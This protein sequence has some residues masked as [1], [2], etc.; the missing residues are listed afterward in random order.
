[1]TPKP[2]NRKTSEKTTA[3]EIRGLGKVF[4]TDL[5]TKV[6]ALQNIDLTVHSGEF[7][8]ILGATGCGKSTFLNL[9]AGLDAPDEGSIRLSDGLQFGENIGYVFQHYTLFPWRTVVKNVGFAQQMRG[10]SKRARKRK[11]S[12][13]LSRVG[14]AGFENAYPH[15]LSGGMRQRAAIAQALAMKPKLLLMDEPFGAVD[16]ATRGD[17]QN[18]ITELWQE[19]DMTIVFVTHNIDEAI[20]LGSRIL[21]LSERPG[22]IAGEFEIDLS[23]PRDRM[24][25]EFT[26]IFME[27]RRSLSG[28]LD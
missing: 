16:D 4:H 9:I 21:V 15:E 25:S 7:L 23:R 2:N 26:D 6:R 14:L 27:I 3:I 19:N 24:N 8:T 10:V 12:E 22:R 18:M 1:M 28:Q 17:L 13:L 5:G 11:T 20:L